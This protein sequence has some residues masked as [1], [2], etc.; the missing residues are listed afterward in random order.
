MAIC[1]VGLSVLLFV[2]V[3]TNFYLLYLVWE[4]R[5]LIPT[6]PTYIMVVLLG[7]IAVAFFM[8]YTWSGLYMRNIRNQWNRLHGKRPPANVRES[9]LP[10]DESYILSH[11]Q[12]TP[13]AKKKRS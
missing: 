5:E 8:E 9:P 11:M 7:G 10:S 3:P 12:G 2:R 1:C 6:L 13:K 4:G